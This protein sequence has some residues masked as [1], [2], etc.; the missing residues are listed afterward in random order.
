MHPKLFHSGYSCYSRNI[1]LHF[2][3][4]FD[5]DVALSTHLFPKSLTS[6]DFMNS[7]EVALEKAL[8]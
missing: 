2:Y 5:E 7:D 1:R 4:N 3:I 8:G 6:F